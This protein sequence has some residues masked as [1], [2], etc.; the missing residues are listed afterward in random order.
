MRSYEIA[1]CVALIERYEGDFIHLVDPNVARQ[2]S[3]EDLDE[4][5]K[6]VLVKL[7]DKLNDYRN[8]R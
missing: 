1:K 5:R 3:Y 8:N 7:E 2:L 4:I 6:F